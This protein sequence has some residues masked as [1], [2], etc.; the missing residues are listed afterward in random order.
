MGLFQ[1]RFSVRTKK[2]NGDYDKT[3]KEALEYIL[4]HKWKEM[5]ADYDKMEDEKK[6]SFHEALGDLSQYFSYS[7]SSMEVKLDNMSWNEVQLKEIYVKLNE[8]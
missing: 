8:W 6:L 7:V 1:I 4:V 3:Y 5:K 2:S